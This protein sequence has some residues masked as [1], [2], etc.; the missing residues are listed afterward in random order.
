MFFRILKKDLKRKKSM[1]FILLVFILLATLFISAS[2]N[3][4]MIVLNGVDNF[5]SKAEISD[6]V[7]ITMGGTPTDITEND[8]SIMRFLDEQESVESYQVGDFLLPNRNQIWMENGQEIITSATLMI[9]SI[10]MC[11]QNFFDEENE[12]IE[13]IHAGEI[14]LPRKIMLDNDIKEGDSI[15]VQVSE[16]TEKQFVVQGCFKDA[17][18]GTD[19]MGNKR[20]LISDEDYEEI[21]KD[22]GMLYGHAYC[23]D[24]NDLEAFEQA[25]SKCEFNVLFGCGWKIIKMCYVMELVI[26]A[27]FLM[28]SICLV[29][30]SAIMLRFTIIFTVNEDYKE[31]GIMKAIGIRVLDIR[32]L[33]TAKY[34]FLA[35]VGATL[36][37]IASIPASRVML[38]EITKNI[39]LEHQNGNLFLSVGV[40]MLVVG[41]V[42]FCAHLSTGKIKKFTPMD[43]IRSGNNGERFKKKGLFKL[44]RSKGAPSTFLALN[45]V[46]TE[47]R[48]YLILL[49][50]SMVGVW[51]IVMPINTIN[52]LRSEKISTWF[53]IT[54]TDV[55]LIED[56]RLS[57]LV[58]LGDKQKYYDYLEEVEQTLSDAG[59]ETSQV[60]TEALLRFR[61]KNG[62]YSVNSFSTQGLRTNMDEYLFDEG[63]APVYENEIAITHII[64]DKLHVTIGDTVYINTGE[65]S[66]PYIVTAIYQSMNNMGEGIRFVEDA[67]INYQAVV[68]GFGIQIRFEEKLSNQEKRDMIERIEALFPEAKVQS[69][70]E[71]IDSMIG[72]ISGQIASLK[73]VILAI[74]IAINILVVV[75]MQKMFLIRE[76][77]EMGML[78][79]VGFSNKSIISWQTKRIVIVLFLGILLG[80]ITGT[81]FSQLTSGQVFKIMGA[82]SIEFVIH[83]M[84]VYVLYPVAIFVVT[85]LACIVTM[86]RV[87]KISVQNMNEIE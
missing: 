87:R 13:T 9:S 1:N 25:Y 84:E 83:P 76:R 11:H 67:N 46:V 49:V 45:D 50:T 44:S 15:T 62:E 33:Y 71:F 30:I 27:L 82:S 64:A 70:V 10:E 77:G 41:V 24:T 36:G 29:I 18:C 37:C 48:K 60:A 2:L 78:K 12:I 26:A 7:V 65:E 5:L 16:N 34:L 22:T 66:Q 56:E 75:L 86:I 20:F 57:E 53:S 69:L 21:K 28:I 19:M 32:K 81:P 6:Y 52:T 54:Q 59:I 73:G 68:G 72:G 40:S 14:Y 58:S 79:A 31:I 39:L 51:L 55:M 61:I 47:V 35:I 74:V 43:A 85:V 23:I 17:F 42:V 4:L 8:K 3:N 80:T 63:T 38:R